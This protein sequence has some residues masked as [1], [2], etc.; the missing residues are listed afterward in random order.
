LRKKRKKKDKALVQGGG[1]VP[2]KK[3]K[4]NQP[5]KT[6]KKKK[7]PPPRNKKKK[8]KGFLWHAREQIFNPFLLLGKDTRLGVRILSRNKRREG[9]HYSS[10]DFPNGSIVE[11]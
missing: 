3:K 2:Q 4:K 6:P 7:H 8:G 9:L 10:R 5:K 11:W 1:K